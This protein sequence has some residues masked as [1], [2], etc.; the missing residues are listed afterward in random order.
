MGSIHDGIP[1][2]DFLHVFNRRCGWDS[3]LK[4]TRYARGSQGLPA[5]RKSLSLFG[6]L[7]NPNLLGFAENTPC[8][9]V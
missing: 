5:G 6:V 3:I 4:S 9:K 7:R 2:A 1:P 8:G